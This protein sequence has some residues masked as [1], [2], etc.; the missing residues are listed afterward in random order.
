M[1]VLLLG[2]TSEARDLAAALVADGVPVTSSL[3]GRVARP[4]LPEGEVR[5]GGFGGVDG[6][7]AALADY[8]VVVDATHPFALGMSRN[9]AAACAAEDVPLLRLERPGWAE[10]ALPSWIWVDTHEQAATVAGELGSRPFLTV[11]RQELAR[12]V[13]ALAER[14]VLAR[15]V[16][17][18]DVTLPPAWVL[19]TSRGPYDLA[20]ERD[21]MQDHAIDVV[22]TKDSGGSYTWPK[23][24]AAAELG[25]P[26]VVVR[27]TPG[28]TGVLTVTDVAAARDWLSRR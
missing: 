23:M 19:R 1:R 28:P 6:L 5:I 2:G 26:V 18:P 15:V 27:R 21:L 9:A 16:D 12:F 4:R 11:G 10:Q 3:A 14:E 8:D 24:A 25:I 13:P 20:G 7:R 22:V 17:V